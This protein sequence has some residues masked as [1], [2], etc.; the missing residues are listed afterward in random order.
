MAETATRSLPDLADPVGAP[1]WKAAREQR[2]AMPH[3]PACGH[4][5]WPPRS[6][7]GECLSPLGEADW[8]DIVQSGTIWSFI[9]YHRA[10]H[11]GFA[12]MVPYNV[13]LVKLDAGPI[14]ITNIEGG[15]DLTIGECVTASFQET[16]GEVTLVRFR[17]I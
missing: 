9:V 5:Q 4:I 12:S 3:C 14:F 10:F 15:N 2:L 17:R 16:E 8:K 13:A 6:L 7:C 11:P 1:F